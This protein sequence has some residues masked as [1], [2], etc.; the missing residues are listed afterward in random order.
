M[1]GSACNQQGF[2]VGEAAGFRTGRGP[3]CCPRWDPSRAKALPSKAVV[4]TKRRTG[5]KLR[6]PSRLPLN[7][8]HSR[9]SRCRRD[10]SLVA[11][12]RVAMRCLVASVH[13]HEKASQ[14]VPEESPGQEK[15]RQAPHHRLEDVLQGRGWAPAPAPLSAIQVPFR[16]GARQQRGRRR[17]RH[18][19]RA[20]L[21]QQRGLAAAPCTGD[22]IRARHPSAVACAPG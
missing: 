9:N 6:S 2:I 11:S 16:H 21:Q 17:T 1:A 10:R 22:V 8:V 12:Q 20:R 18:P 19:G 5:R 13:S 14:E 15:P 7:A 4:H 3:D